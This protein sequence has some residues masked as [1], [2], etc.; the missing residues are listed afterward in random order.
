MPKAYRLALIALGVV[1]VA[2]QAH[3]QEE[4]EGI[5]L[6][7]E[8]IVQERQSEHSPTDY[9]AAFPQHESV[10]SLVPAIQG[11]EA[12]IRDLISTLTPDVTQIQREEKDV[13]AQT[14]MAFWA[15]A[16]FWAAFFSVVLTALGII[17]IWRTLIYTREAAKSAAAAVDQ[18]NAATV[19]AKDGVSVTQR[20]GE[21]Q[22]RAYFGIEVLSGDVV[23]GR[24][25]VFTIKIT[26]HGQSP[27]M[28]VSFAATAFIRSADWKWGSEQ[29]PA[30]E[31]SR[32]MMMLPSG[33]SFTTPV[34]MIPPVIL[35]GTHIAALRSGQALAFASGVCFYQDVFGQEWETSFRF[36]FS[37][38]YCFRS[39]KV[40]ISAEGNYERKRS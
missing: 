9:E 39:G 16:M 13:E 18:A 2:F 24:P 15:K 28:N 12:A 7:G 4:I 21:A 6:G 14:Q 19:A 23:E 8:Q 5:V 25:L 36:E 11:V 1:I 35:D 17:L 40:R 27:A 32:P 37:Q 33:G 20:I 34:D 22:V 26:N 10:K 3:S 38:E 30:P 31:G 29:L